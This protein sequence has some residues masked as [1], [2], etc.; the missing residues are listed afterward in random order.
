MLYTPNYKLTA[1]QLTGCRKQPHNL[2][3]VELDGFRGDE[4][5]LVYDPTLHHNGNW[6]HKFINLLHVQLGDVLGGHTIYII[7]P[8]EFIAFPETEV[9]LV[10][11]NDE[12][13][14]YVP[15]PCK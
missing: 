10:N 7:S 12:L 2:N 13:V 9:P 11:S 4:H 15:I 6:A 3:G 8:P 14:L 1:L 5:V